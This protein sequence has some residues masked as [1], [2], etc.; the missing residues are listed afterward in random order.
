MED[1]AIYHIQIRGH[2]DKK[3]SDWFDG[4]EIEH[5][6]ED[7]TLVG[8]VPDQ[9]ALHGILT[10]IRDLGLF[11]VLIRLVSQKDRLCTRKL[12]LQ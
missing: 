6:S 11:I 3:W 2:L 7:T 10:K 4:F 9:A 5:H 12:S 1:I 8:A